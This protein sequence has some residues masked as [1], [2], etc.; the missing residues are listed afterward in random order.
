MYEAIKNNELNHSE[1][2]LSWIELY[3]GY[4]ESLKK[5]D[6]CRTYL[7]KQKNDADRT[8]LEKVKLELLGSMRGDLEEAVRELKKRTLYEFET[9]N[10]NDL[11]NLVLTERQREIARLR[12]NY[13]CTEVAKMLGLSPKTVFAIYKQAIRKIE[14][15]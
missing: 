6:S 1:W 9:L 13:S 3:I 12:Q 7:K 10:E 2:S 4:R 8:A 15:I 5:V 14:K 11:N